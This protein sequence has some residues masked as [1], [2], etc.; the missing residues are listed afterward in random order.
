MVWS[1]RWDMF[2]AGRVNCSGR[3][4]PLRFSDIPRIYWQ[5]DVTVESMGSGASVSAFE[6]GR[7]QAS[8]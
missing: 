7:V 1:G 2:Q 8:S 4:L 6:E 3:G 5:H